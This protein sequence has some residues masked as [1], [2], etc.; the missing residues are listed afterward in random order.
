M[1][2]DDIIAMELL[3]AFYAG[4]I[5]QIKDIVNRNNHIRDWKENNNGNTLL[6]CAVY[7]D[8][9]DIVKILLEIGTN[10]NIVNLVCII[11]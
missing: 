8:N 4:D 1:E 9:V 10:P 11:I 2:L 5:A 6:H 3:Q 7:I